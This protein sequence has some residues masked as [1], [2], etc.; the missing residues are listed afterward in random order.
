MTKDDLINCPLCGEESGCYATNINESQKSYFCLGCGYQ[1]SDLLVS[2]EYDQE[3]YEAEF[4]YLYRDI[5]R[6]DSRNRVWYPSVVNIQ[7]KGTVFANGKNTE[8][9]QWS[10]IKSTLLTEEDK[11]KL[12]FKDKTHKSDSS[13]LKNF[14]KDYLS[15]LEYIGIEF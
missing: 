4:P 6:V 10:A 5:K 2:G 8:D 7:E 1:S 11:K 3:A 15:A 9:W 13:T 12:I 14:G